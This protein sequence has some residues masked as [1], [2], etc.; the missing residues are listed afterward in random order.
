MNK[1]QTTKCLSLGVQ[2]LNGQS[3]VIVT[4]KVVN[5]GKMEIRIPTCIHCYFD[6]QVVNCVDHFKGNRFLII[7]F[8]G[9]LPV[10]PINLP[11][12]RAW[13]GT[14]NVHL[15]SLTCSWKMWPLNTTPFWIL[16]EPAM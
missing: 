1:C 10:T 8:K 5:I 2:L 6:H 9:G 13:G 11:C 7:N 15:A 3:H 4:V 16:G 12:V 14:L